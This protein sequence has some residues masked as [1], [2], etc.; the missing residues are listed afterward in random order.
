MKDAWN[1]FLLRLLHFNST[2]TWACISPY[3]HWRCGQKTPPQNGQREMT[4]LVLELIRIDESKCLEI[5]VVALEYFVHCDCK[6]TE[7]KNNRPPLQ[8]AIGSYKLKAFNSRH[9]G[10]VTSEHWAC[11]RQLSSLSQPPF[12]LWLLASSAIAAASVLRTW[13]VIFPPTV[14]H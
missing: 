2:S 14:S 4:W 7:K 13:K 3:L 6:H 12:R 11:A 1:N 5:P 8:H 10:K 9:T